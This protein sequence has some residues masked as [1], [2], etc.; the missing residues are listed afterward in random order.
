MTLR[1]DIYDAVSSA[2]DEYGQDYIYLE[3]AIAT[4]VFKALGDKL[5]ATQE[6][7]QSDLEKERA[8]RAATER[9]CEALESELQIYFEQKH[10]E[11]NERTDERED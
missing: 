3:E 9:R 7:L 8:I 2:V 5:G 1:D 10:A 4:G 11:E 6:K